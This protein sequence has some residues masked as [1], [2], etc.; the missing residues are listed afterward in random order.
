MVREQIMSFENNKLD[1]EL[2]M[3]IITYYNNIL[4]ISV[5]VHGPASI[6]L[7][8]Q[9]VFLSVIEIHLFLCLVVE[10]ERGGNW[11]TG[12]FIHVCSGLL[13]VSALSFFGFIC[14]CFT[15]YCCGASFFFVY[16]SAVFCN[17][18]NCFEGS[19]GETSKGGVG[20]HMGFS[21][22]IDTILNW[23]AFCNRMRL[24]LFPRVSE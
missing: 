12:F 24:E 5:A 14:S 7:G 6:G 17:R 20:A 1:K 8:K 3:H 18:I 2:I 4:L 22:R 9:F 21:K 16:G 19:V 23:T 15:W 10:L 13:E 11:V